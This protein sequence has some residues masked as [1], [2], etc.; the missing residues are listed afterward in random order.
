MPLK[1]RCSLTH[2]LRQTLTLLWL[3]TVPIYG[4]AMFAQM[5]DEELIR[6][7]DLIVV[8][9]WVG[10]S[11]LRLPG[12]SQTLSVGAIRVTEVLKGPKEQGVALVIT[13]SPDA[14]RS[15]SDMRYQRGDRGLWLLRANP[16]GSGLYFADHP[17]RYQAEDSADE[18]VKT[19][20]Q[21]IRN[22]LRQ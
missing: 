11:P 20:R 14:P 21:L 19:L 22:K 4:V 2:R 9:E 18:R 3:V 16:D 1:L 5:S 15:N 12:S 7:S 13:N 6:R 17:Q 8:G 10:Q